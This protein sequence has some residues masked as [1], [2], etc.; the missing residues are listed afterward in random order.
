MRGGP[1]TGKGTSKRPGLK[2]LHPDFNLKLRAG[3][4]TVRR[5]SSEVRGITV[6]TR[7]LHSKP[8]AQGSMSAMAM[9]RHLCLTKNVVRVILRRTM[10]ALSQR[11]MV[12]SGRAHPFPIEGI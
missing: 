10:K 12:S 9:L 11:L 6:E 5:G 8:P 3:R 7:P 4:N 2:M 1:G